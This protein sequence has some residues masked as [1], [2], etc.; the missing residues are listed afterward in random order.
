MTFTGLGIVTDLLN[1]M[2]NN[3]IWG[4]IILSITGPFC[5]V[6]LTGWIFEQRTVPLVKGQSLSFFPGEAILILAMALI[7]YN[8]GIIQP[9]GWL[10][11]WQGHAPVMAL[12]V[13]S[14]LLWVMRKI[15][16]APT[17][18]V[19]SGATGNSATKLAHDICGYLWCPFITINMGVPVVVDGFMS[20]DP[21]RILVAAAVILSFG[22]WLSLDA[23]F[24]SR[25]VGH[26]PVAM[27]P[28]DSHTW[29]R[30]RL[31]YLQDRCY[32]MRTGRIA[33][34]I[35]VLEVLPDQAGRSYRLSY[36]CD[37]NGRK[38]CVRMIRDGRRCEIKRG[39]ATPL[40]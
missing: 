16:D 12:V 28:D 19:T 20:G 22:A 29:Y 21:V 14:L 36:Y 27:H 30:R 39:R 24:D 35:I 33:P 1:W 40:L 26:D 6:Y 2:I 15:Y 34:E 17:Y 32:A 25:Q 18:N 8:I 13:S 7:V 3:P 4:V 5:M 37:N 31:S 11:W 10:I 38:R 9:H 23:V